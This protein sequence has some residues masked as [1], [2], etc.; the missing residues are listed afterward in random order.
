MTSERLGPYDWHYD[1]AVGEKVDL[2]DPATYTNSPWFPKKFLTCNVHDLRME[3]HQ[4]IAFSLYYSTILHPDWDRA[5]Y[6]RV[7]AFAV[8]FA[9]E[10]RESDRYENVVWLRKQ[11]F[12]ILDETENQC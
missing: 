4:Q 9:R 6:Q 10:V 5:Q 12:L 2:N 1:D 3:V 7:H 11:L 8:H